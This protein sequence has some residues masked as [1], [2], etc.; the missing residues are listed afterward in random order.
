MENH[1]TPLLGQNVDDYIDYSTWTT[2]FNDECVFYNNLTLRQM[3]KDIDAEIE[4]RK[5]TESDNA[6][7]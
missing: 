5:T 3:K 6:N 2:F 7:S 4:S 1:S